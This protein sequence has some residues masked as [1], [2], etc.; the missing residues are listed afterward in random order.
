MAFERHIFEKGFLWKW[1][2][3][4][5]IA[6]SAGLFLSIIAGYIVNFVYP[7][8][9]NLI[10][11]LCLGAVVGYLQWL[12]FRRNV[13]VRS[14]WGLACSVGVGS[15]FPRFSGDRQSWSF[16]CQCRFHFAWSNN[17]YWNFMAKQVSG[18]CKLITDHVK[19][20]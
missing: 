5:F 7:E 6:F 8:E 14:L 15:Q 1:V 17:R 9:T 16:S 18:K 4:T 13:P 12:L 2:L 20:L 11:G 10:V 19:R 3:F